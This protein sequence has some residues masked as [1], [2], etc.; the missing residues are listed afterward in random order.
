MMNKAMQELHV[1]LQA[2]LFMQNTYMMALI[3]QYEEHIDVVL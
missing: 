2:E 1:E 3:S